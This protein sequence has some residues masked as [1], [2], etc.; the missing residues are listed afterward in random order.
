MHTSC[1]LSDLFSN[2]IRQPCVSCTPSKAFVFLAKPKSA[3]TTPQYSHYYVNC[4]QTKHP[5]I[6]N[7]CRSNHLTTSQQHT[8]PL[9]FP[10]FFA[11]SREI[12][13]F[14][15]ETLSTRIS[16]LTRAFQL[17]SN[18]ILEEPHTTCIYA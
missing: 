15:P 9:R 3:L 17:M 13:R 4:I 5:Y 6:C 16:I 14:L 11:P 2:Q 8:K 7:T 10:Y 12:H 1:S 18:P